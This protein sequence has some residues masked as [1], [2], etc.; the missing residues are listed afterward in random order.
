VR[1]CTHLRGLRRAVLAADDSR[2]GVVVTRG[3][4]EQQPQNGPFDTPAIYV[5]EQ[6]KFSSG[7][8]SGCLLLDT[9][10]VLWGHLS[11]GRGWLERDLTNGFTDRRERLG[12]LYPGGYRVVYVDAD[13]IIPPEVMARNAAWAAEREPSSNDRL[14]PERS[15]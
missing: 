9:G 14:D 4:G 15:S 10:E 13:G 3:N 8:V 12:A 2:R 6:A 7:D 5:V 11:S 1:R